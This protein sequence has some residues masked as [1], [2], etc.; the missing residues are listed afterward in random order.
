MELEVAKLKNVNHML[1]TTT[2]KLLSILDESVRHGNGT[3]GRVME[4]AKPE[5][6]RPVRNVL[7]KMFIWA[8]TQVLR[9][10]KKANR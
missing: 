7:H 6:M 2:E 1:S 10:R 8:A 9:P 4:S 5:I 3:L